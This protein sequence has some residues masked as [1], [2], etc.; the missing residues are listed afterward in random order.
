MKGVQIGV[1]N[2]ADDLD[3]VQL[4]VLNATAKGLMHVGTWIDETGM[5]YVTVTTGARWWYSYY[6]FGYNPYVTEEPYS[7][8]GGMGGQFKVRDRLFFEIDAGAMGVTTEKDEIR[9]NLSDRPYNIHSRMRGMVGIKLAPGVWIYGG[10]SF[11]VLY[12]DTDHPVLIRPRGDYAKRTGDHV[13]MWPGFLGG[14]RFGR[15]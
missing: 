10:A 14:I 1:I 8:G 9:A 6:A 15:S 4:G 11:N 3:G 12:H 5:A 7:F 2:L 13:L